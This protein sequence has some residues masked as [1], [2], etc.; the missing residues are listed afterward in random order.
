M[1]AEI[2]ELQLNF[3]FELG[4]VRIIN[5]IFHVCVDF[6]INTATLPAC[7]GFKV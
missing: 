7:V 6:T 5:L 3:S 1:A 4:L 2:V